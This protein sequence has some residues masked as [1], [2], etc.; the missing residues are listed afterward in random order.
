M[1]ADELLRHYEHVADV[2]DAV[3]RLRRFVLDLAVRG[4][5]VRRD[6]NEQPV[7]ELLQRLVK[8]K[9]QL[10]AGETAATERLASSL[11]GGPP[12]ELPDGWAWVPFGDLHQLI[13]GVTYTK[14]DVSEVPAVGFVP[15]L[16]ANNI[17]IR[18][19]HDEPVFVK[20]DRVSPEQFLRRGDFMIALSSGSKN[21][22]GKAALVPDN[23]TE[24]FGGFCGVIRLHEPCI[25]AFVAVYLRSDLYRES[26]AAGSRGIGINNL[27][28]ETISSLHF[29]LPP[30]PEQHRIVAKVDELM[31]LCDRLEAARVQREAARDRLAA[32]ALARLNAPDPETFADDARFALEALP[33]VTA[34]ADQVK[35]LRQTILN[36]AVRG[37][38]S[39]PGAWCDQPIALGSVLSLQNGYA[40]KSEWFSKTGIRLLRNAN[41][42]H[43][44]IDWTEAVRLPKER[45]AEYDRFRLH[46]GDVV[47]SL[48]R[49]F[50]ATGTKV[51]AVAAGDLPALLLQRVGRFVITGKLAPRFLLLWIN[52]P[53]F[54]EQI[55][56]GRSNGVPHISSKQVEAA[57]IYL[58]PIVEQDRLIAKVNELMAVC[59]QLKASLSAGAEHRSR[60]L[61]ALLHRA[62][63]PAG[64][65]ADP[66]AG[67]EALSC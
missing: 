47:L 46:E 39:T 61:E 2:P 19:S 58:P 38:L 55:D 31:A 5:V 1:N 12:F 10:L 52:S 4:K 56:P 23:F 54:S 37:K 8:A 53:H 30:L 44:S 57:E 41:V 7:G 28:K 13:R 35:H 33:A 42:T 59:D 14:S 40:F 22:V 66:V 48:D 60:L 45:A 11:A 67:T 43:G 18:L 51:A 32:A 63:E 25:R 3:E 9:S 36:L 26:I 64:A 16:R 29:P 27:K 34:R 6:A 65:V 50:I 20:R 24:A 49:P 21:L 15:I 62:L 17:G